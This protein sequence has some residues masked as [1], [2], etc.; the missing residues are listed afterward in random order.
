MYN[1]VASPEAFADIKTFVRNR[2]FYGKLLDVSHFESEQAYLNEKRWL[3]N[4]LVTGYGVICGLNVG[5]TEDCKQI[6]VD[7][8]VAIDKAGREIVVPVRS[9][10][11]PIPEVTSAEQAGEKPNGNDD[12]DCNVASIYICY[13][14]CPDNPEPI[15]ASDCDSETICSDGLIKERYTIEVRPYPAPKIQTLCDVPD[16]IQ[17]GK[18]NYDALAIYVTNSDCGVDGDCCIPLA[19]IRLP[20]PAKTCCED[21]IDITVRPIVYTND[22]LFELMLGLTSQQQNR[23]RGG[24]V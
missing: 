7:P 6:W 15:R 18:L 10:S 19:N 5:L 24:K 3:L 9:M 12:E 17:G 4:R 20:G 22:L 11:K 16:L 23:T 8:G 21:D 2:Y 14:D 13:H 1:G